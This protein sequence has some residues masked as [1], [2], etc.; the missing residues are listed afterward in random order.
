MFANQLYLHP[1]RLK[2][3]NCQ[4]WLTARNIRNDNALAN[5]AKISR[6]RIQVGSQYNKSR[7]EYLSVV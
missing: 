1:C 4:N 5:R 7:I 2:N 6:M 3:L